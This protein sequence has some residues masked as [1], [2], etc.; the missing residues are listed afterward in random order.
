MSVPWRNVDAP[1]RTF[2]IKMRLS[3]SPEPPAE[4]AQHRQGATRKPALR[5]SR[6][7]FAIVSVVGAFAVLSACGSNPEAAPTATV[8]VTASTSPQSP[9]IE[10]R[11]NVVGGSDELP[12]LGKPQAYTVGDLIPKIKEYHDSGRWN[13]DIAAIAAQARNSI[14]KW[15]ASNCRTNSTGK[16]RGC[17]PTV[18]F[19]IDDTLVSFYPYYNEVQTD[20]KY[21]KETFSTFWTECKPPPIDPIKALY[22]ELVAMGIPITLISGRDETLKDATLKCLA[23]DGYPAPTAIYLRSPDQTQSAAELK[24]Q[25]R[26]QIERQGQT[27]VA[28]IGD[29]QA[30]IAG[31]HQLKAFL[32]PNPMY[33]LE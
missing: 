26:A 7:M 17:S 33:R 18:V 24:A 28:N 21:N 25:Y 4:L 15:V 12:L 3:R 11:G 29:Q 14:N 16:V 30:D 8:T 22:N 31:G 5:A 9:T 2:L 13:N 1:D 10:K 27:V 20:W 19:D 6:Q 32:L 23:G